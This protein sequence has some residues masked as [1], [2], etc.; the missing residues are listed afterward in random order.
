MPKISNFPRQ[1]KL[2]GKLAEM[3]ITY[4]QLAEAVGRSTTGISA[5]INGT[6]DFKLSLARKI[7]RY[8]SRKSKQDISLMDIIE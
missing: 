1:N 3:D 6:V 5:I 2:V 7:Q 4:G 8:L